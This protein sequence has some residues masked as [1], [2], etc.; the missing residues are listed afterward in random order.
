MYLF[1]LGVPATVGDVVLAY[2]KEGKSYMEKGI[3]NKL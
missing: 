2:Y 1:E 3:F